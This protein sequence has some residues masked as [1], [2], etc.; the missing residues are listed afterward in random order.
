MTMDD[1]YS[2]YSDKL[3]RKNRVWKT[4][5]GGY[6]GKYCPVVAKGRPYRELGAAIDL[7]ESLNLRH[8]NENK[9]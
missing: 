8:L 1:T 7:I 2:A 4:M 6:P 3:R 5:N 9:S